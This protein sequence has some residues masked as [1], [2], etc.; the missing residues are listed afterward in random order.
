MGSFWYSTFACQTS[1]LLT[2]LQGNG[3]I[4]ADGDLWRIQRKAGLRFFSNSNLKIFIDNT[5]PPLL[6]DTKHQLD[7]AAASGETVDLQAT[8][9]ELTTRLMGNVAYDVSPTTIWSSTLLIPS[10]QMDMPATLPFSKAFDFASGAIG[11]RFQNPFWKAKEFLWGTPLRRAV[12]EIKGFGDAIV[13]NAIQKRAKIN[14]E[15][16]ERRPNTASVVQTNLIDSLLDHIKD[17]RIV[18]DAAMNYLSAGKSSRQFML[19]I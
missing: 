13:S 16:E 11:D 4:N 17:H 3:I 15:D 9:L 19:S 14:V 12:S 6:E 10:L 5:L 2:F 1:I 18:A 7:Y 8:L